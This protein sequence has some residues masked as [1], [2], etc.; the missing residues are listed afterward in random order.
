MSQLPPPINDNLFTDSY[1]ANANEKEEKKYFLKPLSSY[2]TFFYTTKIQELEQDTWN[3]S[4]TIQ[5]L[6]ELIEELQEI[7]N[8]LTTLEIQL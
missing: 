5:S 6:L 2:F 3:T 7:D 4:N 1:Y 8:G